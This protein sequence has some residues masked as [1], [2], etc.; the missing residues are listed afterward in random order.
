LELCWFW[1]CYTAFLYFFSQED[2]HYDVDSPLLF[3]S[4]WLCNRCKWQAC[5]MRVVT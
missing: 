5:Q 1:F 4:H 3:I 2:Q